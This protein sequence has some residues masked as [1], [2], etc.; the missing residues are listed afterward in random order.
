MHT[1]VV[2]K[3]KKITVAYHSLINN[4]NSL[5]SGYY[6]LIISDECHRSI[7]GNLGIYS[8][9]HCIKIELTATPYVF[10]SEIDE[11]NEDTIIVKDTLKFFDLNEPSFK[12][13]LKEA[14]KDGYLV[15]Y[16]IY[17]AKTVKTANED[18]ISVNKDEI[19]FESLN[20]KDK[21]ELLKLYG[22]IRN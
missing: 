9:F 20:A 3:L 16:S 19:D 22:I 14:I 15:P 2:S 10:D 7:Y 8:H 17:K 11:S 4:Y 1:R 6:D 21:D 12:Y 13:R 5:T 18:G